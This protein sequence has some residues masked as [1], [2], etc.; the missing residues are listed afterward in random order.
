MWSLMRLSGATEWSDVD[1]VG[2]QHWT[3]PD[4]VKPAQD[5]DPAASGLRIPR[6]M[7]N[8]NELTSPIDSRIWPPANFDR[9]QAFAL[10]I[11]PPI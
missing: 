10:R 2:H 8:F 1:Y 4:G 11:E 7:S 9:D 6:T 3:G 5:L